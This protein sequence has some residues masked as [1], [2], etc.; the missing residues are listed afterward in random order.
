M[1]VDDKQ[2]KAT[3]PMR[4][5]KRSWYLST[6]AAGME[7]ELGRQEFAYERLWRGVGSWSL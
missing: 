5:E 6:A 2:K 3:R 7:A 1:P 4:P